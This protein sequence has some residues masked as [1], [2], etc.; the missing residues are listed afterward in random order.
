M[1]DVLFARAQMGLSLAFHIVFAAIGVALPLMMVIAEWRW[2]RTKDATYLELTKR[3]AKGTAILFAVG[4][5]SGTVLSF[6]LSLLFPKF[7]EH[8]G[9]IVG[10]PFSLEGFAFFAEAIFLAIYLYGWD[11]VSPRLHLLSGV[12]VA[13]S[14]AASAFFVVLANAWM[15]TPVGFRLENGRA[16]DIDPWQAMWSPAA[17]HE[18][19]HLLPACYLATAAA[20]GGVHA[21]C[22]LRD[23]DNAFHRKALGI[24]MAVMAVSGVLQVATGDLAAK[25]VAEHQPLKFAAME[26]EFET[27]RGAPARI[28]GIPNLD[29]GHTDYAIEIPKLG[30]FLA[31]GDFDAEVKG[32]EDFPRD[33]WPNVTIVHLA[34][35]LMIF[36]GVALLG[37]S[38]TGLFLAWRKKKLPDS[39]WMLRAFVA[40]SP[41]GFVGIEAGWVVTEMGRQPWIVYGVWKTADT[42]TPM[43][44]LAVPFTT[45]MVVYVLLSVAVIVLLRRQF[46][47]A[48]KTGP[49]DAA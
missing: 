13:V 34:F 42:V 30:S 17:F 36:T 4:A 29:E 20:V 44:G 25:A 45:F 32:L 37:V 48:P 12:G 35:Q 24:S 38:F 28:G 9:A 18:A 15:N 3:W 6:E 40:V 19:A 49:V 2:L 1:D 22:L 39:K 31:Y 7:M 11:K 46:R 10:M 43:Q 23:R 41:L 27:Q 14:G 16:V 47:H 5:V 21:F 26:A 33:E 8:A